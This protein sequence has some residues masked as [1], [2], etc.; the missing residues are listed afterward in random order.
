M[1]IPLGDIL[2]AQALPPFGVV[3]G[4][5]LIA[6]ALVGVNTTWR[7]VRNAITIAHEGGHAAAAVLT[8]RRLRGIR[9][10]SDTSGLTIMKGKPTGIGMAVTL[11][12]GYA[13]P[14]LLGIG[15][16]ALLDRGHIR[17]LLWLTI[18]L[19]VP[20]L[21]MIRNFYGLLLILATGA[22][23]FAVSWYATGPWQ[24]LFAYTGV[25]FLLIGGVR[26]VVEVQLHRRR[27]SGMRS[28]PDQLAGIT[29]L[30]GGFWVFVFLLWTVGSVLAGAYLLD[31]LP[32]TALPW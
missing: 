13:T 8:G 25:W 29:R 6:L 14:S 17:L 16:A 4:A 9:L 10:H 31:L 18:L 28:D 1:S 2:G 19:L 11:L 32:E 23:V 26:P 27:G 24:A 20:I 22:A 15:G 30:P 5:A 21:I 12:A 3:A 7:V